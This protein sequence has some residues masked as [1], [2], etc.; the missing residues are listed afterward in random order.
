MH[1]RQKS[2]IYVQTQ[3]DLQNLWSETKKRQDTREPN[4]HFLGVSDSEFCSSE[5]QHVVPCR[6]KSI[7]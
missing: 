3:A 7:Q 6:C 1:R 4:I 5:N 2:A